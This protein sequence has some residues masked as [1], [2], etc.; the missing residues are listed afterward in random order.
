[1]TDE[2][3]TETASDIRR[4]DWIDRRVPGAVRPYFRLARVD[5][6]IGT[7]RSIQSP[8]RI[9]LAVSVWLSPV[10]R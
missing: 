1:M 10:M 3:H 6:A 4:G 9:S 7:W 5:R 8:R 2:S